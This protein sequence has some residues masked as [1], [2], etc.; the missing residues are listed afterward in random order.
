MIHKNFKTDIRFYQK[1]NNWI[2]IEYFG[3]ECDMK[4]MLLVTNTQKIISK[5]IWQ[6]TKKEMKYYVHISY[7]NSYDNE[8][9]KK[10]NTMYIYHIF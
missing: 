9:K 3:H 8:Q 1:N 10:W 5:F 7:V 2:A 6:R 4:N